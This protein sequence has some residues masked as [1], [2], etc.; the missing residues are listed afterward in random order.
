MDDSELERIPN[1]FSAFAESRGQTRRSF[2]S[3]GK[4]LLYAIALFGIVMFG[5]V[6]LQRAKL[7]GIIDAFTDQT[8]TEKLLHLRKLQASDGTSAISG[9]VSAIADDQPTVS[10]LA[11]ELM[12][13]LNQQWMALP[14]E[15]LIERRAV[16]V[17]ALVELSGQITDTTDPRWTRMQT[18]AR[19]AAQNLIDSADGGQDPSARALMRLLADGSP[20]PTDRPDDALAVS[21]PLPVDLVD[22]AGASWTDW[23]PT[24][25]T[26][27]LYRSTVATLDA[28]RA[29]TVVLQQPAESVSS[30]DRG[31]RLLRPQFR[32]AA[33]LAD[34]A[35]QRQPNDARST[36]YWIAQLE[37]GSR[38]VR[39]RAVTELGARNDQQALSA[40]RSHV[41][42]ETDQ[43]VA[44]LIRQRLEQ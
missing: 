2:V 19:C 25:S 15:Q 41:D 23:P 6:T 32:P 33:T 38:L 1:P 36:A 21:D 42:T 5:Q 27:T 16:F 14:T 39:M 29:P 30:G 28:D 31:A 18:L 12:L 7:A 3:A 44:H 10:A 20:D 35:R 9:I 37:S 8:T 26:P 43:S 4:L 34:Q 13:E 22:G 40:L 17:D 11:A 24:S